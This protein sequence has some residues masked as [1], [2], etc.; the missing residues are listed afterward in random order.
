MDETSVVF[1][2]VFRK[3]GSPREMEQTAW[4]ESVCTLT[5]NWT[6]HCNFARC[7]V[8]RAY[9]IKKASNAHSI[10]G[11]LHR[12]GV[13]CISDVSEIFTVS[14]FK[15]MILVQVHKSVGSDP[16]EL[17]SHSFKVGR[18][19]ISETSAIQPTSTRCP[20]TRNGAE[21]SWQLDISQSHRC[22]RYR[23]S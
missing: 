3:S 8:E 22:L 9:K 18:V 1:V 7:I 15:A 23:F 4:Y 21:P 20:S 16:F 6:S 12:V 2:A 13:D 10:S 17:W 14:I 19:R 5:I 11:W